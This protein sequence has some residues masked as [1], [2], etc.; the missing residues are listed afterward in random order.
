MNR[1][2]PLVAA[3]GVLAAAIACSDKSPSPV[4][5]TGTTAPVGDTDAAADGSN[6]KVPA[7]T[8]TAPANGAR[9]EQFEV[10]LKAT[11]VAAKF[12]NA[13][14]FA[15]RF[16]LLLNGQVVRDFRTSVSP[17]WTPGDLDVNVEYGW[18]VRAE[19][20][21]NFGPWSSTWTFRTPDVPQGYIAGGEVYDPLWNG[22]SVGT[23][24]GPYQFL[25]NT[26]IKLLDFVS[27]IEYV[28]PQTVING[29]F[30][31]LVTNTPA[32]TEGGKTKIM[33]MAQ[34][35]SDITTNDR[36]FTIEKRGDPPGTIAFRIISHHSQE[37]T[38][39]AERVA[40][41]FLGDRWY[42]WRA[43]WGNGRFQLTI[44][45]NGP[46]GPQLYSFGK[47][48]EGDYDPNPHHA[49]VGAPVGRGGP[50]DATVPGMVVK[51]VWLS[52]RARPD[53]ANK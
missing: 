32:N 19:Q 5:P 38:V 1:T 21:A 22:K 16:Q 41:N 47:N 25:P 15:Y 48:Y 33:S 13:S 40:V 37:E 14:A 42:F 39:G 17:E 46:S 29:E 9:L 31:M 23:I 45:E 43:R 8:P 12:T 49:W 36:R 28:L 18:R 2:F 51:Q 30:S 7:P 3:I 34:G 26:G 50:T 53:F 44:N 10:K 27:N 52:S 4:A 35:R 24:N 11:P 6:L 20:G